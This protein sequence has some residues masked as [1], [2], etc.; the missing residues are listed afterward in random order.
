MK[1]CCRTHANLEYRTSICYYIKG[2]PPVA[3]SVEHPPF[4]REVWWFEST[5][6]DMN[7]VFKEQCI[8]LRKAGL[9]LTEI[10]RETGRPKTS[11]YSYIRG[12]PLSPERLALARKRSGERIRNFPL[13]RAGKSA[14][15]FKSFSEWD[16]QRVSLVAHL[17][18]D[19]EISLRRG[20]AYNNRSQAL[21]RQFSQD[22]RCVYDFEPRRYTNPYTG[23]HRV[24]YH[25]V[26]LAAYFQ[27]KSEEL[28]KE[29]AEMSLALQRA[30]LRAFFDDEGCI[31]FR[32]DEKRR[33]IRG[34]QKDIRTLGLVQNVLA[35]FG[36]RARI[37]APNEVV[38][39]GRDN[40]LKF[41]QEVNFSSGVYVNGNRANSRW[42]KDFEKRAILRMA[43]ESYKD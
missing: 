40:L 23:V 33:S 31:D 35:V 39:T 34:Y 32:I 28:L 3:Q 1:R 22:M 5:R 4:K 15:P 26:A 36:I 30:F 14:K 19:G 8:A 11:I 2:Y 21:L 27:N 18:F 42:K 25:N 13:A 7:A 43:I 37:Q 29:I 12:I 9:S 17:L 38:I 41:E 24:S 6:A 16:I 10:V 20:C